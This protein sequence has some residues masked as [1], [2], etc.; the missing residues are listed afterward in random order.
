MTA[1]I[2]LFLNKIETFHLAMIV[3]FFLI[4]KINLCENVPWKYKMKIA[5]REVPIMGQW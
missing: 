3:H 2:T 5:F 1:I 4:S